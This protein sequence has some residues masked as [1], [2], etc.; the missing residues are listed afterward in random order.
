M[1]W[2]DNH[3]KTLADVTPEK[4]KQWEEEAIKMNGIGGVVTVV[5]HNCGAIAM[6][7]YIPLKLAWELEAV[8]RWE[9]SVSEADKK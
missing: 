8:A 6:T 1:S 5:C 9:K 7:N 2:K 4:L 3:P